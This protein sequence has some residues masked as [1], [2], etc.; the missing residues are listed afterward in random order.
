[1]S[2]RPLVDPQNKVVAA[3]V[4]VKDISRYK[5]LEE[6]LQVTEQ[7]YRRLIGFKKD[8]GEEVPEARLASRVNGKLPQ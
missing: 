8:Q 5:Q 3:V 6:E 2:G 4:T 1:M 7:K